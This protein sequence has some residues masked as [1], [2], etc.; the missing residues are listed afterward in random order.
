M[1]RDQIDGIDD[2]RELRR[3]VAQLLHSTPGV[4]RVA[5]ATPDFQSAFKEMGRVSHEAR[6]V[7][8]ACGDLII[9]AVWAT[10]TTFK[11]ARAL[12]RSTRR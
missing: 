11:V 1:N 6:I 12:S 8:V 10:S 3:L 2:L 4:A 9:G 5:S 7:A